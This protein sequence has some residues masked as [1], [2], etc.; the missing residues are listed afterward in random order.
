[1]SKVEQAVCMEKDGR[2]DF[3]IILENLRR[4]NHYAEENSAILRGLANIIKPIEY[5]VGNDPI[6][7]DDKTS[8]SLVGCLYCEIDKLNNSNQEISQILSHLQRVIGNI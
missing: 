8:V 6:P 1:M 2:S 3:V 7:H 4:Q 5:V